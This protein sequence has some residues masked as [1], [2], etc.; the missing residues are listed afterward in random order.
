MRDVPDT[1]TFDL[2]TPSLEAD[3][4]VDFRFR[5][6]GPEGKPVTKYELRHERRLHLILVSRDLGLFRHVHPTLGAHGTWA[7]T[8]DPL[9]VGPYRAYADCQPANGPALALASDFTMQPKRRP[10]PP[11]RRTTTVDG[12]EVELA[13]TPTAG[14]MAMVTMTVRRGGQPVADLQS[15]LGALGHMVAIGASDL[16]Y[17]HVH[18]M[19][20]GMGPG[21]VMFHLEVPSAGTYRLFFEFRHLGVVRVAPFTV[22]VSGS[23]DSSG[24]G[25]HGGHG[26]TP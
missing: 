3:A 24:H 2:L 6:L 26:A 23:G 25:G 10:L 22:H 16:S 19:D 15:Y 9:P 7:I 11:P 17:L 21:E 5:V 8:L 12:Y 1:Y 4:A 13:G 18:A 20:M 14:A